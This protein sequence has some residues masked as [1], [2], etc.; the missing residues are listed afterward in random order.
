M[1]KEE[2]RG[3]FWQVYLTLLISLFLFSLLSR[4]HRPPADGWGRHA[5]CECTC[6]NRAAFTPWR[7]C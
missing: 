2:R 7:S 4:G 1:A 5:P 6:A 3:L